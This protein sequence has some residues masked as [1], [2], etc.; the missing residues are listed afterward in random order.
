MRTTVQVSCK[1]RTHVAINVNGTAHF[2]S[3]PFFSVY[4]LWFVSL[5]SF[6]FKN[7]KSKMTFACFSF[8][9]L[10]TVRRTDNKLRT[11]RISIKKTVKL[12]WNVQIKT[13]LRNGNWHINWTL[14]KSACQL[15]FRSSFEPFWLSIIVLL[16]MYSNTEFEKNLRLLHILH[17]AFANATT[18]VW[19][20]EST[21][22]S[23]WK[24]T[25]IIVFITSFLSEAKYQLKSSNYYVQSDCIKVPQFSYIFQLFS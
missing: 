25:N 3:S 6:P 4:L 21:K 19:Q 22:L 23:I 20:S 9:Y 8:S 1:R 18:L 5:L 12:I 16:T 2:F 14:L 11:V 13:I 15:N 10:F 17:M 24:Q 7:R